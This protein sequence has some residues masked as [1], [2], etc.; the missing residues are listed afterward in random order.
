MESFRFGKSVRSVF[1]VGT[2]PQEDE[3]APAV[4]YVKEKRKKKGS[5]GLRQIGKAVRG[6]VDAQRGFGETYEMGHDRSN[7]K[8][9][10]GWLRDLPDNV[11]KAARNALKKLLK[12]L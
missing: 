10:D 11:G 9:K 5:P 3:G 4:L 12:V 2:G 6:A 8:K 1:V 7:L